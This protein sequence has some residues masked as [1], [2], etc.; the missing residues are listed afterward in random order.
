[1]KK[2]YFI[3]LTILTLVSCTDKNMDD[4]RRKRA[5]EELARIQSIAGIYRGNLTLDRDLTNLG[6]IALEIKASMVA[7]ENPDGTRTEAR[8]MIHGRIMHK[9]AVV[10]F[11]EGTYEDATGTVV[12]TTSIQEGKTLKVFGTISGDK[13]KATIVANDYH[14]YGATME[15][16]K[17][18]KTTAEN[19]EVR[20]VDPTFTKYVGTLANQE[21]KHPVT[22][23]IQLQYDTPSQNFYY[24]FTPSRTVNVSLDFK[25]FQIA[26]DAGNLDLET[27]KL[28]AV[29]VSVVGGDRLVNKLDCSNV[30]N[31]AWNCG[32]SNS[33]TNNTSRGILNRAP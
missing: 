5:M 6:N 23:T 10:L 21:D 32:L 4:Y 22:M 20:P 8:A 16:T 1:M 33:R 3:A 15:L 17:N 27:R 26:T 13:F 31:D 9:H 11:N 7:R 29:F 14:N 12:F 19:G 30:N 28:T 24:Q 25:D 2:L 18:A